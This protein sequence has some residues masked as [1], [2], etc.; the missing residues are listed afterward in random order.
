M[1]KNSIQYLR[2]T[3]RS[4]EKIAYIEAYLKAQGLFRNYE[5]S[6]ADPVFSDVL[7][8]DLNTIVPAL[9]GPKRPHDFVSLSNMKKDFL[10]VP[11]Y[12]FFSFQCFQCSIFFFLSSAS[13]T[14]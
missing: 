7:E 11:K 6:S 10:D 14:K 2:L 5:D 4:E 3:G 12:L 1:D 9:A 13:K 8:I